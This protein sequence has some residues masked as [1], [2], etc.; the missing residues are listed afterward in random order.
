MNP[1]MPDKPVQIVIDGGRR[2]VVAIAQV[3]EQIPFQVAGDYNYVVW[4]DETTVRANEDTLLSQHTMSRAARLLQI[5]ICSSFRQQDY[6]AVFAR[7][8]I[9]SKITLPLGRRD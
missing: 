8:A 9:A 2:Y 1:L 3:V 7:T 5:V 6:P 4:V